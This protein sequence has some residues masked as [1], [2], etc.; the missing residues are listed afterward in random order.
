MEFRFDAMLRSN[1]GNENSDAG[2]IKF[3]RAAGSPP[4]SRE[5]L[6]NAIRTGQA[7][8]MATRRIEA[9]LEGNLFH[10]ECFRHWNWNRKGSTVF[11]NTINVVN[12]I[13]YMQAMTILETDFHLEAVTAAQ[14]LTG[15]KNS[16]LMLTVV[17]FRRC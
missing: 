6:Q 5:S 12:V 7:A 2:H 14:K 10:G 9:R 8:A 4:W 11:S 13:S 15:G 1:L 3:K 16:V 17:D